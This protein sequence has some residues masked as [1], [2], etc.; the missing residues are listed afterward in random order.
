MLYFLEK[1]WKNRRSVWGLGP[2]PPEL[3]PPSPVS[4]TFSKAFVALSMARWR[5]FFGIGV[6]FSRKRQQDGSVL[7]FFQ[8]YGENTCSLQPALKNTAPGLRNK[9]FL[10][11]AQH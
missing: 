9:Y 3:L 4:V 6:R 8:S 1:N 2:N 5:N 7:K 11:P 10:I